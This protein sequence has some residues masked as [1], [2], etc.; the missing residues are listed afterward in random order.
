MSK[1]TQTQWETDGL[2]IKAAPG[3][4]CD[5]RMTLATMGHHV[6]APERE[7]NARLISAAP[8]LLEALK[9]LVA[10]AASGTCCGLTEAESV[11]AYWSKRRADVFAAIAKATGEQP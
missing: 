10:D 1:H 8:E 11:A 5:T 6:P 9:T 3:F 2:T 7:A 4:F